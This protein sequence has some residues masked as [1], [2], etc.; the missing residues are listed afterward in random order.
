MK[1]IQV[2]ISGPMAVSVIIHALAGLAAI[3]ALAA[4]LYAFPANALAY[5]DDDG[6]IASTAIVI[7][8]ADQECFAVRTTNGVKTTCRP[9]KPDPKFCSEGEDRVCVRAYGS[10]S[11][12][13]YAK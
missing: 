9:Y 1:R 7:P 12:S 13:C 6:T 8:L 5:L 4:L 11:C 2:T 10:R 3:A